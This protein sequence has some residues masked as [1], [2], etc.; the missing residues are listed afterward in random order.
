MMPT[1]PDTPSWHPPAGEEKDERTLK[2]A[3]ERFKAARRKLRVVTSW[4]QRARRNTESWQRRRETAFACTPVKLE[5]SA[6]SKISRLS[7]PS[8]GAK[9]ADLGR[10][11]DKMPPWWQPTPALRKEVQKAADAFDKRQRVRGQRAE[12]M[13]ATVLTPRD[14][15]AGTSHGQAV[16]P[17]ELIATGE[18]T[19][20]SVYEAN[21]AAVFDCFVN[22]YIPPSAPKASAKQG[23]EWTRP[24][25]WSTGRA[26]TTRDKYPVAG[27]PNLAYLQGAYNDQQTRDAA[28]HGDGGAGGNGANGGLGGD[29][30]SGAAIG[31]GTNGSYAGSGGV[32]RAGRAAGGSA[33]GS[34]GGGRG[35]GGEDG[36]GAGGSRGGGKGGG[37]KDGAGAGGSAGGGAGAEADAGGSAGAGAGAEA[38]AGANAGTNDGSGD[39]DTALDGV[40]AAVRTSLDKAGPGRSGPPPPSFSMFLTGFDCYSDVFAAVAEELDS[41]SAHVGALA[42]RRL[43]GDFEELVLSPD[44]LDT[45]DGWPEWALTGEFELFATMEVGDRASAPVSI[46]GRRRGGGREKRSGTAGSGDES[47]DGEHVVELSELE[48]LLIEDAKKQEAALD[49]AIAAGD[50]A[51]IGRIWA[52][53]AEESASNDYFDNEKVYEKRFNKEHQEIQTLLATMKPPITSDEEVAEVKAVLWDCDDM[54]VLIFDYYASLQSDGRISSM[55]FNEC[56]SECQTAVP[57]DALMTSLAPEFHAR[58][59]HTLLAG[60]MFLEDFELPEPKSKFSNRADLDRVF[61]AVDVKQSQ[62]IKEERAEAERLGHK[63]GPDLDEKKAL[64]RVEFITALVQVAINKFIKPGKTSSAPEAL[65]MLC[66]DCI[67]PRINWDLLPDPNL[68]RRSCYVE[69]VSDILEKY[70]DNLRVLHIDLCEVEFGAYA[71]RLG[72]KTW[73]RFLRSIDF[74]GDDLSDRDCNLWYAQPLECPLCRGPLA[75]RLILN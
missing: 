40:T 43:D 17:K 68:F 50:R 36:G 65:H 14:T 46:G 6:L 15:A 32:K 70:E 2:T 7:P 72:G 64:K 31:G 42:L 29:A 11:R 49:L 75:M 4:R 12:R 63:S 67:E 30:G 41:K 44:A 10:L 16:K 45:L 13:R 27:Y 26:A 62:L 5:L 19:S 51:W 60:G 56:E 37:G 23:L 61:I 18:W 21:A 48:Q 38:G 1:P 66:I 52:P 35:G 34:R 20:S 71:K 73:I 22:R 33:G 28:A 57:D 3:Q 39:D 24:E 59:L 69:A 74:L 54:L 58:L 55:T 47:G 9:G 8:L 53:R 25:C